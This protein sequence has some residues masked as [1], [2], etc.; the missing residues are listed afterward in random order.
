MGMIIPASQVAQR[1]KLGHVFNKK[2]AKADWDAVAGWLAKDS[3]AKDSP[4]H[5]YL[6]PFFI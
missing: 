4:P 2:T 5:T 3:S 6:V 1:I